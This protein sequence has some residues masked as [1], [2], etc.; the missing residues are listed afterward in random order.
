[1]TLLLYSFDLHTMSLFFKLYKGC[2]KVV[3]GRDPKVE[4]SNFYDLVDK[5][6]QGGEVPMSDFEGSVILVTNVAS[7]W[8]MTTQNYTEFSSIIDEYGPRGLKV[9]AF[10]CNQF[11]NQEPGSHEDILKF[12]EPF[13][14]RDKMTFFEKAHVNGCKCF[15]LQ[16]ATCHPFADIGIDPPVL[17]L[18]FLN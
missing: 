5:N 12:V 1:M 3:Y 15:V 4:K 18:F 2:L 7:K 17:Y 10:P 9:L 6:M 8:S 11:G 13:G 16:R 14:V